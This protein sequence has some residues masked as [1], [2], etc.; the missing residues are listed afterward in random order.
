MGSNVHWYGSLTVLKQQ[1]HRSL[2]LKFQCV[3]SLMIFFFF[4][5]RVAPHTAKLFP[6]WYHASIRH[7]TCITKGQRGSHLGPETIRTQCKQDETY[8]VP[9]VFSPSRDAGLDL[10]ELFVLTQSRSS[11]HGVC[12]RLF[13]CVET[14]QPSKVSFLLYIQKQEEF[15]SK[16]RYHH[17]NV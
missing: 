16:M 7:F 8:E 11:M 17:F 3:A 1:S 10:R 5:H 4:L 13:L 6:C 9:N 14:R 2:I 12:L 15:S